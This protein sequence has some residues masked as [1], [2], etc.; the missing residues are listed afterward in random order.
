M[1]SRRDGYCSV[2]RKITARVH[3][4]AMCAMRHERAGAARQEAAPCV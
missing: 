1:A 2:K 4:H 3:M